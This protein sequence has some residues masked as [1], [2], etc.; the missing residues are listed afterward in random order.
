MKKNVLTYSVYAG[1]IDG[2][3]D[4]IVSTIVEGQRDCN[5]LACINPHSY[6]VAQDDRFFSNALRA[7]NW[8]VP[9]GVGIVIAGRILG[10]PMEQRITGADIFSGVMTALNS[11]GGSVFF[12][13]GTEKT[14]DLIRKKVAVDFPSVR[15]AGT[16]SPPFKSE[17]S[18]EELDEM[19]LQ[20]NGS[21]ADVLWVGMTAPKQEKWIHANRARLDVCFAGAIGAVF[22]FYTGQVRRSHPA[23]RNFG[24]EWLPRLAREPRRLWRRMFVSAPIFLLDVLRERFCLPFGMDR[25]QK[26]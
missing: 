4:N 8:L 21:G 10:R 23:F 13:G 19:V 2:C 11:T 15:L 5:W 20:V 18:D 16:F 12:L 9:D 7:A 6:A 14:L 17:Y 25:S 24:L 3:V 26:K 22:D 1:S